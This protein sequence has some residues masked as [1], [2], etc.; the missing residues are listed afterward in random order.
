MVCF[1]IFYRNS[2]GLLNVVRFNGV[3]VIAGFVIGGVPLY[4][5]CKQA[6]RMV[7]LLSNS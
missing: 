5:A 7:V 2:A 1:H 3:F 4:V 6:L